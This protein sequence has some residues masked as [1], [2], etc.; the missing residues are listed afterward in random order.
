MAFIPNESL[1]RL[2]LHILSTRYL[3]DGAPCFTKVPEQDNTSFGQKRVEN[4]DGEKDGKEAVIDSEEEASKKRA[5]YKAKRNTARVRALFLAVV[6]RLSAP[7]SASV[8]VP[9]S[10]AALPRSSA[11]TFTFVPVTG[12]SA[13]MSESSAAMLRSFVA[14]P[15]SSVAVL[16]LSAI[17]PL[18]SAPVS[19]SV[20]VPGLST[21]VLLSTPMLLRSSSLPFPILSL[22]KTPTP[23]LVT[24]RRRLDD[25]ISGRSKK[26]KRGF[27]EKLCSGKIKKAS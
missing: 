22:P 14:M 4:E 25:T 13:D 17:M 2:V 21:L 15:G 20:S 24:G 3:D 27:S 11:P 23:D 5:R 26:S 18:L 6:P 10:S 7:S 12:L 16:R 19:A 8:P 9:G 1:L